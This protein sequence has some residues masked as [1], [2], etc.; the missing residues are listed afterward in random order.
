MDY[1]KDMPFFS[2]IDGRK[3]IAEL[4]IESAGFV[5]TI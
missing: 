3:I 1:E 4:F 2:I 5:L